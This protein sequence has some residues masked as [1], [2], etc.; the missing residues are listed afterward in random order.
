MVSRTFKSNTFEIEM[1]GKF[2]HHPGSLVVGCVPLVPFLLPRAQQV[3]RF[4]KLTQNVVLGG[5]ASGLKEVVS[6]ELSGHLSNRVH[7]GLLLLLATAN[8]S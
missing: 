7:H 2:N 3:L 8:S 4:F 5:H 6:L 1:L